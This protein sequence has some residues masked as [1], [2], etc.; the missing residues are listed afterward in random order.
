MDSVSENMIYGPSEQGNAVEILTSLNTSS[1]SIY[2]VIFF[3]KCAPPKWINDWKA[4][5]IL[6]NGIAIVFGK[7][8]IEVYLEYQIGQESGL[9]NMPQKYVVCVVKNCQES[10]VSMFLFSQAKIYHLS[11]KH[12]QQNIKILLKKKYTAV[13]L[14]TKI[15]GDYICFSFNFIQPTFEV[16]K[17]GISF[18]SFNTHGKKSILGRFFKYPWIPICNI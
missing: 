8:A 2:R 3:S 17:V 18:Q 14:W 11:E 7:T 13:L 15:R 9:Y 16:F 10:S 4:T 5:A 6:A 1:E 12:K